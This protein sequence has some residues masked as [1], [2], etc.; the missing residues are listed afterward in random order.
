MTEK[1]KLNGNVSNK[2]NA[3]TKEEAN[4]CLDY[5]LIRKRALAFDLCW[6]IET[7]MS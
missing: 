2:T 7:I 5:Q 6:W 4:L 1:V 3:F